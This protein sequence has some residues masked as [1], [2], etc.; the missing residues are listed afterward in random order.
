MQ[1]VIVMGPAGSGKTSLV[2]KLAEWIERNVEAS[3]RLV[4]L[5]PAAEWTPY[6]PDFDVRSLVDVRRLMLIEKL[7]PN[8]A[9][10][11]AV[12][13]LLEQIDRVIEGAYGG[14][15]DYVLIDTPGQLDMFV[16]HDLGECFVSSI[17]KNARPV[18]VFL[19]DPSALRT[20]SN[21]A[22]LLLT[23]LVVRLRL[24]IPIVP[25]VSKADL[26]PEGSEGPTFLDTIDKI[27]AGLRGESGTLPE[28]LLRLYNVFREFSVPTRLVRVSS[29]SGKGLE[30]LYKLLHEVFCVCGD[31]T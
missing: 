28:L 23:T 16:F 13:L 12:G 11:K 1:T 18:G 22:S 29:V 6:K 26:I 14:Y 30:D 27:A 7:G 3:V 20:A 25:I 10:I 24:N 9:L 17:P 15:A 4:N 5:D 8:G 21:A 19:W 2:A 31:L